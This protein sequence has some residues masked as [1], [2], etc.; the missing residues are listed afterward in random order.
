MHNERFVVRGNGLFKMLLVA[1][2]KFAKVN[3]IQE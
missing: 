3:K 2:G 1:L